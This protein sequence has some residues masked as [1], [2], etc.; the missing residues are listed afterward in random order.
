M[1]QGSVPE[2]MR[3]CLVLGIGDVG[4]AVALLLHRAGHAV[5]I[6]DGSAPTVHR[7][8]MAFVD[9]VFDGRASL[10]GVTARRF[11]DPPDVV[12]ALGGPEIPVHVGPVAPLLAAA[13]WDVLIDARL[14]KRA[15]P[16]DQR[17]R[18][19]QAIG[20]GPGFIA[21]VNCDIAVETSW[22]NLG[23]VVFAGA[24]AALGG[25]PRAIL[26]H[27]R[28]RVVYAPHAGILEAKCRIGDLVVAGQPLAQIGQTSLV[29]PLAGAVRGLTR[30]GVP[31]AA[32]TKVAEMD[33]RGRDGIWS[34]LGERPRRIAEA[35]LGVLRR[36]I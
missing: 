7:R 22:D 36:P 23:A 31:V 19:R 27:G 16:E 4:S 20:L 3:R 25:E 15:S 6:H 35:V 13:P 30:D 26:G 5:A 21:G 8:A 10:E 18:A 11:D 28:E 29:A 14:R 1:E 12:R 24:T 9:A 17:G 34:G 32:G 2:G 33:P